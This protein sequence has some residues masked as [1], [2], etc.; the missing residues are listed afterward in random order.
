MSQSTAAR[1]LCILHARQ[2][3][4]R[5]QWERCVGGD[6]GPDQNWAVI[7]QKKDRMRTG[8]AGG[9]WDIGQV[10]KLA[11]GRERQEEEEVRKWRLCY[12]WSQLKEGW[13]K[14]CCRV[15]R[16]HRSVKDRRTNYLGSYREEDPEWLCLATRGEHDWG[17]H[18]GGQSSGRLTVK[19]RV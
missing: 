4:Q 5:E 12:D 3:V 6:R 9:E 17:L 8:V 10:S 7:R 16:G 13:M 14:I 18:V 2:E 15:E 19:K 11:A 1:V